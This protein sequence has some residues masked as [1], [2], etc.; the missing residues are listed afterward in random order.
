[1]DRLLIDYDLDGPRIR[2]GLLWFVL[3]VVSS[4]VGMVPVALL[5][6]LVAGAAGLQTA[7][8]WRR[9][10][11]RPAQLVAGFGALAM[12]L[13]ALLGIGLAGVAGLAYTAAAALAAGR[14]AD[15][16]VPLVV[17][18]GDTVR[19]GFFV[20]LAAA[21]AVLLARTDA[22]ALLILVV[23]VSGYEVG[24]YVVG[25]GADNPAEGPIAGI[26]AVTVLTFA[27]AVFEFP[28]FDGGSAWV[29]GLLVA[30]LAPLGRF[31]AGWLAPPGSTRVPALRRLDSWL[32]V[33]PVWAFLL[34]RYLEL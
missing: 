14:D 33:A 2:L 23:L 17:K 22:G 27:V 3:A 11:H 19:S 20:G 31:V 32:I 1:V 6:G 16:R 34:W 18:M 15:R 5:F 13:A 25:T 10:G 7:G 29:F 28:P 30:A 21:A 26:A 12:P 4:L 9:A 24:D 8:A